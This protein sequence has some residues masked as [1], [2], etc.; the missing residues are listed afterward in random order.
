MEN[1]DLITKGIASGITEGTIESIIGGI[2]VGNR[3]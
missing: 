3:Q 1:S 2:T